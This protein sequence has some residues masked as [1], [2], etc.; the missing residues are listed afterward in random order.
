MEKARKNSYPLTSLQQGMV[1]HSLLAPQS[2]VFV[3]QL[4]GHLNEKLNVF[5]F[6]EAWQRVIVRHPVLRT[7]FCLASMA[8]FC[9]EV[10]TDAVPEWTEDDWSYLS[11]DDRERQWKRYLRDDRRRG[12]D[13][14]QSPLMRL[15]L[16]G[17]RIGDRKE[18]EEAS[19]HRA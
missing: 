15:F 11:V 10:E 6:K 12:F 17:C 8:E 14:S 16:G 5:A 2:G 18:D 7:R 9:Q 4:V 19:S 3:Q 1:Y 13:F